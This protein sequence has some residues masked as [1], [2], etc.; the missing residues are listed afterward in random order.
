ML[1]PKSVTSATLVDLIRININL[2]LIT[3]KTTE[4]KEREKEFST[5]K[6]V[7]KAGSSSKSSFALHCIANLVCVSLFFSV[8]DALEN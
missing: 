1:A 7:R 5:R 4:K 8:C 3:I 6:R 2:V